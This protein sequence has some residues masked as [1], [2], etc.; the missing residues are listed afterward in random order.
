MPK[1]HNITFSK[2][3]LGGFYVGL[4]SLVYNFLAFGVLGVR[5]DLSFDVN[6]FEVVLGN[7]YL[8]IF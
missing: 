5:P 8:V 1:D 3:L 6:F 2:C 7:F 4:I